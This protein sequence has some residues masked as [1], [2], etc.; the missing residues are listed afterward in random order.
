M[1]KTC[2]AHNPK[3]ATAK[4]A[5]KPAK[6]APVAKEWKNTGSGSGQ[7]GT[8]GDRSSVSKRLHLFEKIAA[9]PTMASASPIPISIT[10]KHIGAI[11]AG[12]IW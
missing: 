2:K 5:A 6:K 12:Q 9:I 4:P 10:G 1:C 11:P 7:T 3:R 8:T